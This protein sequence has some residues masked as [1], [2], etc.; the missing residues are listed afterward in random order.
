MGKKSKKK[1]VSANGKPRVS[2]C[3]PTYNRRKFLPALIKCYQNQ[4]YPKELME[5][6]VIDDGEDCVEDLFKN[7]QGVKYFRY[8]EKMKLGKKRNIMNSKATGEI[9]V[10]MDDDDYYPPDRVNHA[11]NRLRSDPNAMAVGS[12]IT[13]IYFKNL[14]KIYQ[15]GPYAPTHATAGTFAFKKQLLAITSYQDDADNA[16]EKYFLKNYTVPLIQLNPFKTILVFAHENNTFDKTNL[17]K[18]IPSPYIRETK[19]KPKQFI[20]DKKL[21]DFYLKQ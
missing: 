8:T 18:M 14:D 2:V 17:L 7:I 16:E 12:S 1:C 9:I 13:Y 20:N 19:I 21:L 15:F 3:T 10:Y 6:I 5:W 4:T 11:V